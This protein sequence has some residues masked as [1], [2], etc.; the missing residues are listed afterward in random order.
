MA[1]FTVDTDFDFAIM[2]YA[3]DNSFRRDDSY[4]SLEMPAGTF[5]RR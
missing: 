3:S 5:F 4:S 2:G 1:T